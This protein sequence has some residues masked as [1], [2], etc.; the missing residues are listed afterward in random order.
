IIL[1]SGQ[2][3]EPHDFLMLK[4]NN[5]I[6]R[7]LSIWNADGDSA[8]RTML[9]LQ[10]CDQGRMIP[11]YGIREVLVSERILCQSVKHNCHKGCCTISQSYL[12]KIERKVSSI[13][14]FA[15]KHQDTNSFIINSAAQYSSD[16][17]CKV[18]NFQ[19]SEVTPAD[20][21]RVISEGLQIWHDTP[22]RASKKKKTNG[23]QE[24][25]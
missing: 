25:V 6:V 2:R 14:L 1:P 9:V 21:E 23:H 19:Y 22:L 12:R 20:W 16:I 7:V 4:A 5:Q 15:M 18:L 3:V 13:S 17:H 11:F 8:E 24:L 10:I